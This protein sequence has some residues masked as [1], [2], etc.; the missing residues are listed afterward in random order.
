MIIYRNGVAYFERHATVEDELVLDVPG[1]RVDDFLKSLTVVDTATGKSL[2]LRIRPQRA[3]SR[4]GSMRIGTPQGR[5][6]VRIAYVTESPAWK[7]SY[8]VIL[9]KNGDAR[10]QSWGVVDNVSNER[11]EKVAIG[12]G[13]TSALSFRYDLHSVQT[14]QRET[15][16]PA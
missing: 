11:W 3:L 2:P 1:D 16:A 10:L 13:S 15:I 9:D 5:R 4:C 6:D 8:R 12:V 14:V 7:P